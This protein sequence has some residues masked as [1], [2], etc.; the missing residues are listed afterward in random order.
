M[1]PRRGLD[2]RDL[3]LRGKGREFGLE[4]IPA[5]GR[6]GHRVV[7]VD[8]GDGGVALAGQGIGGDNA[9]AREAERCRLSPCRAPAHPRN[10]RMPVSDSP[11]VQQGRTAPPQA[12]AEPLNRH[13]RRD[14]RRIR[15]D[16][17]S[18]CTQLRPSSCQEA[19]YEHLGGSHS[20][21]GRAAVRATEPRSSRLAGPIRTSRI[22][23]RTRPQES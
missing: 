10:R 7:A 18:L 4:H 2:K 5:I 11:L 6:D 14:R 21:S 3:G 15:L 23:P 20:I 13:T 12:R 9:H 17:L 22:G 1:W 19:H 8:V 16:F